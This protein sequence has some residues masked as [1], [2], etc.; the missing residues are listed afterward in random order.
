MVRYSN[1][2]VE[3]P[4]YTQE[5]QETNISRRSETAERPKKLLD[6]VCPEPCPEPIEGL[7]KYPSRHTGQAYYLSTEKTYVACVSPMLDCVMAVQ[8]RVWSLSGRQYLE[9]LLAQSVGGCRWKVTQIERA[10]TTRG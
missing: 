8:W 5:S 6:Q 3:L 2:H 7:S 4:V 1:I 9:R 10:V